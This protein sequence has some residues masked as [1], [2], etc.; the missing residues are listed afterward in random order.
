MRVASMTIA[1]WRVAMCT[2]LF[3]TLIGP[4]V[5]H[6]QA[7]GLEVALGF[8]VDTTVA[9][10]GKIVHLVR[11]Y[12][13]QPDSTARVRKLWSSESAFDRR[14]G[15]LTA[16]AY[17]GFPATVIGVTG[18]TVE[19][20]TSTDSAY[21]VKVLYARYDSARQGV[22]PLA[23]QRLYAIREPGAPFEFQLS[24]ALPRLTRDWERRSM[25]RMT[26]W[27]APAQHPDPA[28]V[29]RA[30]HFVDSVASLFH[31]APPE[32][33]D[34][35]ITASSDEAQRAIGLDF[36]PGASGPGEGNGGLTL[37]YGVVLVGNPR[38]G[39]AYL[40]E[41][42]HVVLGQ[43]FPHANR[44]FT[45]G[46]ATWLGGSQ[47]RSTKQMYALLH[48]YQGA[49]P[50]VTLADLLGGD[51]VPG[52]ARAWTDVMYATGALA[53]DR[54]YRR[55]GIGGL[56]QFALLAAPS[57]RVLAGLPALL[58][59]SASDPDAL[60]RWWHAAAQ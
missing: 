42:V 41:F 53:A 5:L 13:A 57:D 8:G 28:K 32:H 25:G 3:C 18:V 2:A 17:Q 9:D 46:V 60:N 22:T 27:Y 24:G 56:R 47:D 43:S 37:P 4:R 1:L 10:V 14:V 48:A 21:V 23:L 49:H 7:P 59:L 39:E 33:M 15:D 34:V 40:H 52:G 51:A 45:E 12:L 30:A 16:E 35:Y 11:A 31:V 55:L 26:F 6:A 50:E 29:T 19:P 58:G 36:F 20:R 44:L 38:I 54:I